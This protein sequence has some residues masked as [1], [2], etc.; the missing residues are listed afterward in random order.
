M[1]KRRKGRVKNGNEFENH[2]VSF[3]YNEFVNNEN[4]F[5][6]QLYRLTSFILPFFVVAIFFSPATSK[7]LYVNNKYFVAK[8]SRKSIEIVLTDI[9]RTLNKFFFKFQGNNKI[10]VRYK[11]CNFWI[12]ISN[13]S[14]IT[15]VYYSFGF[16]SASETIIHYR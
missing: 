14:S 13:R 6:S 12:K 2:V 7:C 9:I 16:R 15:A 3:I 11:K 5:Q 10:N 4:R 1:S 8:T